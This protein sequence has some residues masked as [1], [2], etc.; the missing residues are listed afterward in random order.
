MSEKRP[1]AKGYLSKVGVYINVIFMI[2]NGMII[3]G[4]PLIF[5][6]DLILMCMF[7]KIWSTGRYRDIVTNDGIS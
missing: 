7:T 2:V 3:N 6:K 5:L 4:V 1:H